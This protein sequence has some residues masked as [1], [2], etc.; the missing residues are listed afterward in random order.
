MTGTIIVTIPSDLSQFIVG[1]SIRM[2]ME[3]L[4]TPV[5]GLVENMSGYVCSQ[6]GHEEKL[7]PGS[8]VEGLARRHHV[9]YLGRIPFDPRVAVCADEG[10]FFLEKHGDLP[11]TFAIEQIAHRVGEFLK[12]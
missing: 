4:R 3:L 9:P 10:S 5:I 6:C 2:A 12:Q 1:K 7:F 8:M 11:A